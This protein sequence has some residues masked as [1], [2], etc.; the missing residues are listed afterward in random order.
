[1]NINTLLKKHIMGEATEA[2]R[3]ELFARADKDEID[4]IMQSADLAERYSIYDSIRKPDVHRI[5]EQLTA[6]NTH[7]RAFMPWLMRAAAIVLLLVVAAGAYW[8]S[9]QPTVIPPKVSDDLKPFIAMQPQSQSDHAQLSGFFEAQKTAVTEEQIASY[10]LDP[11]T[12]E[13]MLQAENISTTHNKEYW[14]TL[15][16]GTIVHLASGSRIIYP[17][18][19]ARPTLWNPNPVR[20]VLL[21]GDAYFLVA[22]DTKRTFVVHTL[23]GD[24]I[25]YG[26]EFFVSTQKSSTTVAL[27]SGSVGVKPHG[28]SETRLKPGQESV[29][30]DNDIMLSNVDMESYKAWNT[31]KYAFNNTPLEQVL[32]VISKWYGITV[33]YA[34]EKVKQVCISGYFDRYRDLAD[35]LDAIVAVTGLTVEGMENNTYAFSKASK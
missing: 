7:R 32:N 18:H 10:Q 6:T 26:T 2:E 27:I 21:D 4:S 28:F 16:D 15:D 22:H 13:E 33:E 35:A 31:G 34:D 11:A 3:S 24:V 17:E 30:S 19:F 14:L 8:Y 25:D 12:A 29:F 23:H 1:M 20:E 9:I 5:Y